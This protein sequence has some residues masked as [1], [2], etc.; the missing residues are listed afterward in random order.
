MDGGYSDNVPIFD[1]NTITISP[2]SG[3]QD[4]CPA[5][6]LQELPHF[7]MSTGPTTSVSITRANM[8][9]L[10]M[11]MMPPTPAALLRMCRQGFDDTLRYLNARNIVQCGPC[12]GLKTSAGLRKLEEWR[13]RRHCE[14]PC[15]RCDELLATGDFKLPEDLCLMFQSAAKMLNAGL[16]EAESG[17]L[18]RLV[19]DA[20]CA[21]VAKR[22]TALSDNMMV[23]YFAVENLV[24]S[25]LSLAP[26]VV[27]CPFAPS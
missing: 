4:I 1:G 26:D 13:R 8:Q 27:V 16:A 23:V 24:K 12:R 20:P 15:V 18:A 10:R 19:G 21:A 14:A 6:A 9:R 7:S 17:Y 3:D 22:V 5:D 11:A 25:V 2:F